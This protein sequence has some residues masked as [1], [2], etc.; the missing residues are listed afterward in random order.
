MEVVRRGDDDDDVEGKNDF[1]HL[2]YSGRAWVRCFLPQLRNGRLAWQQLA[3]YES[4][5]KETSTVVPAY[6]SVAP[7]P[8]TRSAVE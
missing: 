8:K 5:T 6:G 3:G 2:L 4:T 7:S 1:P